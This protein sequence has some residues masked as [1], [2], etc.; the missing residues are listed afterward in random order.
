MTGREA[1]RDGGHGG[2]SDAPHGR[3]ERKTLCRLSTARRWRVAFGQGVLLLAACQANATELPSTAPDV[4]NEHERP[5]LEAERASSTGLLR[6]PDRSGSVAIQVRG[7]LPSEIV[8]GSLETIDLHRDLHR[9]LH[10]RL[11]DYS[12][13]L[14]D[15]EPSAATGRTI[16][17][18]LLGLHGDASSAHPASVSP[19]TDADDDGGVPERTVAEEARLE[20]LG[21]EELMYAAQSSDSIETRV[22]AVDAIAYAAAHDGDAAGYSRQVLTQSLSDP[23]ERM[24]AQALETLKDTADELPMESIARIAREDPS[25]ELRM[26]ALELLVERTEQ[27]AREPLRS[28]LLDPEPSVQARA[29]ELVDDW[30]IDLDGT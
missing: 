4:S 16:E 3:Q 12:Y 2:A 18:L 6:T 30:H 22:A 17:V 9:E 26:Q 19:A 29:R 7:D 11:S 27:D 14:I 23:D 10:R 5:I 8:L 20:E 15:S 28:A 25:P 13:V 24:R 1:T 21:V